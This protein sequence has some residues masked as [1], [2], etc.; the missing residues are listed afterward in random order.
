MFKFPRV[1]ILIETSTGYG[2]ELIHGIARYSR[3]HG[4]WTFFCECGSKD[5]LL[6]RLRGWNPDGIIS[7]DVPNIKQICSKNIPIIITN[8]SVITKYPHIVCDNES[9]GKMAA[10]YFLRKG[11]K[12]FAYCGFS[13]VLW[14]RERRHS[15]KDTIKKS[16]YRVYELIQKRVDVRKN[17]EKQFKVLIDWVK[18][19]PLPMAIVC[20]NDELAH[21]VIEASRTLGRHIPEEIAIMGADNDTVLCELTN[22]PLTSILFSHEQAGYDAAHL[23]HK[24]MNGGHNVNQA[25]TTRPLRIIERQSTEILQNADSDV[26]RAYYFIKTNAKNGI[27]VHD[28]AEEAAL[29]Q[30]SLQIK[31]KQ[32][33]NHSVHEE[34]RIQQIEYVAKLLHETNFSMKKIASMAGFSTSEYMSQVFHKAKGVCLR[35]YRKRHTS[36]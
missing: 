20:S 24:M 10:D 35:D 3:I 30:R 11:A 22:P 15:F 13:D 7:R 34:I 18:S 17:W 5:S 1:V 25:V 14:G 28:V 9:T 27:Q 16:G 31:F 26:A 12:Q 19:L 23:L 36:E 29:S 21:H 6:P 8:T 4:P 2:R 32:T 33:F